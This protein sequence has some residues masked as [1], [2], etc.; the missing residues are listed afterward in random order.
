MAD[1]FGGKGAA[2]G[3]TLAE[4]LKTQL[5]PQLVLPGSGLSSNR[6]SSILERLYAEA[7]RFRAE[8]RLGLLGKARLGQ[9]FKWQL[10]ELGYSSQ[11]VD[12]A[13]EGL[14]VYMHRPAPALSEQE[15][16]AREKRAR[17]AEKQHAAIRPEAVV[18][19]RDNPS[20]KYQKLVSLYRQMHENGEIFLHLKPEDT[21]PGLSL[22]PQAEQVKRLIEATGACKLLDYGSGKGSQYALRDVSLPGVA[23]T[24]PSI[25]QYWGVEEVRCYDPAYPP[26]SELPRGAFD[27]VICT[28]VLE[29]CPEEDIPW[30]LDE[31]FSYARKFVFANVACYP[32]MKKL[33]TGENAHCTIRPQPWWENHIRLVCAK[34]PG[35]QYEIQVQWRDESGKLLQESIRG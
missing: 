31:L 23:G 12:M 27:G 32:A 34:H 35:V 17:K 11:F 21:F 30:I 1:F 18:F 9:S 7:S 25:E 28:D 4:R 14:L 24:W 22:L 19:S 16:K 3:K 20:P 10:A 2:F 29:H 8:Q 13:T 15:E 5:P 33:P 26:Y 6:V